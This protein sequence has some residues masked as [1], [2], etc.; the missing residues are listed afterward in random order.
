MKWSSPIAS[1][2][3]I[4][5]AIQDVSPD[6]DEDSQL[7]EG[8]PHRERAPHISPDVRRARPVSASQASGSQKV[9]HLSLDRHEFS[10][11]FTSHMRAC[12]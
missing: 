2:E 10:K 7:W 3:I 6:R 5:E 12:E 8:G 11:G 4:P 1:L 9:R